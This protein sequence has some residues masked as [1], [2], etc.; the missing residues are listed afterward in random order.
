MQACWTK[1]RDPK[2]DILRLDADP[3]RLSIEEM[4]G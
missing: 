1:M 4:V 2:L 3:E